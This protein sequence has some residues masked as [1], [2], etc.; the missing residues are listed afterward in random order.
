MKKIDCLLNLLTVIIKTEQFFSL[1]D[2]DK[3]MFWYNNTEFLW[4]LEIKIIEINGF[5]VNNGIYYY[6][7]LNIFV[8]H[9]RKISLLLYDEKSI[10]IYTD[11]SE[12]KINR[13]LL[14]FIIKVK[15]SIQ[16]ILH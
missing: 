8:T 6:L 3:D 7:F 15:I 13:T 10:P 14:Q 16:I 12:R 4:L 9:A 1:L 11:G 2:Y 5:L